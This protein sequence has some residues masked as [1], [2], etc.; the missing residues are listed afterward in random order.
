MRLG[1]I[2][3]DIVSYLSHCGEHGGVICSTTKASEFRGL[4]LEQV[5][6]SIEA[7]LRRGIIRR[8]GIRY[9]IVRTK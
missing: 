9:L 7:L 3:Q 5:Q 2:Q 8:E 4:D 1:K 6:R